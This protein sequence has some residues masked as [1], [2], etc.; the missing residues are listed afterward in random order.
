MAENDKSILDVMGVDVGYKIS[1]VKVITEA[2]IEG[3]ARLSGDY[4][5]VHMDEDFA[6]RSFFGGR[7]AHGGIAITLILAVMAK[8]PGFLILLSQ[9]SRFLKAI[10]LGDTVTVDAEVVKVQ[11]DKGIVTA[12]NTCTNQ[13]GEVAVEGETTIRIFAPPD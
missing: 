3:Y 6:R 5:P 4:N 2:D 1:D 7:I 11:R 12:R 8:F 9:S 13:D 10:K